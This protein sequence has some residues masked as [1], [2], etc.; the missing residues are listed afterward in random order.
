MRSND[1]NNFRK[2]KDECLEI[3]I[4]KWNEAQTRNTLY[5]NKNNLSQ[6]SDSQICKTGLVIPKQSYMEVEGSAIT[7]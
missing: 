1:K 7:M 5:R 3:I 4:G 6:F 2:E